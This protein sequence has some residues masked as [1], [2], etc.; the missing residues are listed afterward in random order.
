MSEPIT[1]LIVDDHLLV[2]QGVR[3]FF[4]TQPDIRVLADTGSG[5][6]AIQMAAELVPDVVLMDLVMPGMDGV[7]ATRL[8]RRTSPRS[9]VLVLTSYHQDE[10]IFPAIRAGA[11]SYLLKDVSPA[12][13]AEAVRKAARGE[14]VLH[15]R[16][17][18][19]VVQELHGARTD[20]FN[21]FSDL[22]ERELE[23][24]RLIADGMGNGEIA[25]RLVISEKT[26]KSHVSN[27]L[28]KL[29]VADRTQAA[30]YAWREGV[31]RREE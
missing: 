2:R 9:Q 11:L 31:M 29:H 20:A 19:R 23:V 25:Q 4:E 10:H 27:I 7:E 21:P 13:L 30:V 3:A 22:S 1:V 26:V 8:L 18:A 28:S 14:A 5:D 6:E 15:P 24:L 16:I 12:E 17:A